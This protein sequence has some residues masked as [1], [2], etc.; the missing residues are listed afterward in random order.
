MPSREEIYNRL[1]D[2][3][4]E[5][6][7]VAKNDISEDFAFIEDLGADSLDIVELVMGIEEEFDILIP[8][9]HAER[10]TTVKNAIDYIVENV[11]D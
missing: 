10:I 11:R 5:K 7:S 2:L 6:L 8:D 1:I 4:V 3:V 9:A